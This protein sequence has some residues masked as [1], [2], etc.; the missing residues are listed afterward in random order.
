MLAVIGKLQ[1]LAALYSL[2]KKKRKV[3]EEKGGVDRDR[4]MDGRMD[5]QMDIWTDRQTDR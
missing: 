1:F 4:Q 2:I 3:E 5:G